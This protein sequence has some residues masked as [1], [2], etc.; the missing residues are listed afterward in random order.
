VNPRD[1]FVA[2]AAFFGSAQTGFEIMPFQRY[3]FFPSL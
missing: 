2:L 1:H 3:D